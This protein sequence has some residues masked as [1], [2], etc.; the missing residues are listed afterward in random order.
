VPFLC[1]TEEFSSA[2]PSEAGTAHDGVDRL[3]G[4][5]VERDVWAYECC[6]PLFQAAGEAFP[7]RSKA[8]LGIV[9]EKN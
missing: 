3:L 1:Q 7:E 2:H 8:R 9:D 6:L 4:H 5:H